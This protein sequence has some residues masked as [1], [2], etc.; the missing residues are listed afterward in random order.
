MKSPLYTGNYLGIVIQNNDP[1]KRGRIKVFVPHVSPTI[2]K[3]WTEVAKDKKFKFL[4]K[5]IN[6]DITDILED[7]KKILP[8]AECAAPLAGESS[9][10][11]YN[12]YNNTGTI[13]DSNRLKTTTSSTSSCNINP[14]IL[15]KYTQNLDKIG[16]KPGNLYDVFEYKLSDAFTNPAETNVN[17]ANKF[18][19]NYVPESYSNSA[20]GSFSIPS[21]G[22]HVWVFFAGGEPMRPIYFATSFGSSD[23]NSIYNATSGV[24]ASDQAINAPGIDYP[25][26]Y[27]N[28]QLGSAE[29]YDIN[30]ETYRNK[31]VI[32]QKGGTLAFV[33][34]DNR[35]TLKL[36]HF[37]GSFK[38]FNNSTNIELATKNDQKLVL[39]DSFLTIKGDRNEFT[40][41]DYDLVVQGNFYKKIGT[42]RKDLAQEWK[43]IVS[44]L[45]DTKQLFDIQRAKKITNSILKYTSSKQSRG[46][47]FGPC[48]V[49]STSYDSYVTY[50]N[51][52]DLGFIN[53]V[54]PTVSDSTGDYNFGK[55]LSI[56][57]LL[58]ALTS[59][60]VMGAPEIATPLTNIAGGFAGGAG[61]GSGNG[62]G[63]IFG[64]SCPACNG[65]GTS[66]STQDGSWSNENKDQQIKNFFNANLTKLAAI[67]E[68]LGL[69]GSEI[70]EITKHKVE[71]IGTVMN[72]FGSVRLDDVGKMEISTV[73]IAKYGAFY[74]RTPSPIL[75]YVNVDDLPGGNYALNVCNRYSVLV[76]AGGMNLKSY[77]PVNISGTITNVA[78]DQL[79]LAS[80]NEVNIDGGQRVSIVGDIIS[81][82][83]RL[84]QQVVVDSSLGVTK[85]LIVGGGGY[86]D[87]EL[88]VN[89]ITAP[90]EYQE[91]E[92]KIM[93]GAAATDPL[94]MNGK[95]LGFGVPLSN[96][97]IK[98]GSEYVPG[99]F[100][101]AGPPYIGFTDAQ[102]I[103]GRLL[104]STP[105][106][107]VPTG[108]Y[109]GTYTCGD[110]T[111][112][113]VTQVP[114]PV[115]V[116]STGY[117]GGPDVPVWGSGPGSIF[118]VGGQ[119]GPG[120][121]LGCVKGTD[122]GLIPGKGLGTGGVEATFMP[123]AIYGT[124]RDKDS[125][126]IPEHS[127][128][129]KNIPLSLHETNAG[130]RQAA[131]SLEGGT[132]IGPNPV[133][134][135]KK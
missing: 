29:Q 28:K 71:T 95:L 113:V 8:W 50:N 120:L 42:L 121:S 34:T 68:Q 107:Y 6:S 12:I 14:K 21:V 22:A 10:G 36:T 56:Q 26:A 49:C 132:A 51:A 85:N 19:Y 79:N 116:S 44:D 40:Q 96:Y 35:E 105:V 45:A 57:G 77:G 55:T 75:E 37:S 110:C 131:K 30:V 17:N 84:K 123:L 46:G 15:T 102:M 63:V 92:K 91:T 117:P 72:D 58:G 134:N 64:D 86:F 62:P 9:S 48:P 118:N 39:E 7:L 66:K 23:W 103:C 2:Y 108:T 54:I 112:T 106:G 122:Q 3:D 83:Q 20:K 114:L 127:H 78:G 24:D 104:M 81:I 11:R 1:Q 98:T 80:N 126:I 89:H 59:P 129:F 125:I 100:S 27:E 4:G 88:F 53:M 135:S 128:M 5:N 16:E 97:S 87:G 76:G 32:N 25:G 74:D 70:I 93:W 82:R 38:E 31:F 61:T 43:D 115:M 18:S 130:V 69:G 133:S 90:V 33:N 101:P 109:V 111:V 65:S 94:N 124:G 47:S 67:E 41:R 73:R 52:L 99:P 119:I 13:S 60:G